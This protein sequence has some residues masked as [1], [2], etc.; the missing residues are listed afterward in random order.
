MRLTVTGPVSRFSGIRLITRF[1]V[2]G[3]MI[4]LVCPLSL[5]RVF[6]ETS[7]KLTVYVVNYPLMYF[8]GRIAGKHAKV[9]FPAPPDAD[10]ASWSPDIPTIVSYQKADLI[11]LNGA[12]YAKWADRVSLPRAKL[13]DT[14]AKF[15]DSYIAAEQVA[16]HRHGPGGEH[17]H[18]NIA[19]TTWLDFALAAKQ[20]KEVADALSRREPGFKEVFQ[21]NYESLEKDLVALDGKVKEIVA[22]NRKRP[23]ISS[24]PVYQYL[25][26]RY[27]LNLRSVHW[28]PD[29]IPTGE[30]WLELNN[31]LKAHPAKWMIWERKPKD[32]IAKKLKRMGI[33]SVVFDPCESVP[34]EG[35]FLSVMRR[36]IENLM[37]VFQEEQ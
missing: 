25:A 15:K 13:V 10:P 7:Y 20:A 2:F 3:L 12:G 9:V 33:D 5:T 30:Q 35:D 4:I 18:E 22:I 23:I 24:H 21:R 26:R 6:A 19:S 29:R 32:E 11:L 28:E 14:S 17:A 27:N 1:I 31:I 16:T 34:A 8:T 37:M 36:N